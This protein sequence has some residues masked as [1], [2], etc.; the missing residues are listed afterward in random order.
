MA[1]TAK[2]ESAIKGRQTKLSKKSNDELI[3]II[4]RKDAT[5]ANFKSQVINLKAEVNTLQSRVNN[6]DK[7][8]EG[9]M[10]T[11]ESYKDK[12]KTLNEKNDSISIEAK[13]NKTMY[14][15]EAKKVVELTQS[16]VAWRNY[17]IF[18]SI[19]A[20]IAIGLLFV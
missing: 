16:L 19:A 17:A 8:M 14:D 6:F 10:Q 9:T 15:I 4:L 5:E 13:D 12:V 11:L 1:K 18:A 7:D 2:N 3:K 20:I